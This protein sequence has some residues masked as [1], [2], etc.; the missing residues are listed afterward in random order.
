MAGKRANGE[1]SVYRRSDGRWVGQVTLS[2]GT[3]KFYYAKTRQDVS[4][5]VTEALRA[6]DQGLPIGYGARLTVAAYLDDWLERVKPTIRPRTWQRYKELLAHVTPTLGK[7]SVTRLQPQQLERLYAALLAEGLSSTTVH[8]LSTVLH[9]ALGDGMRKGVLAR[10][11]CELADAPKMR[12]HHIQAL[13]PEQAIALLKAAQGDRNEVLYTLALLTGMRQGEILAL[14]W[15]DLDLDSATPSLQVRGSLQRTRESGLII[16]EPKTDHSR[17]RVELAPMAV[18]ALKRHKARQAAER[19]ALGPA[20]D[21]SGLVFTNTIG[22]P[23]EAR[24]LLRSYYALLKS[25]DLPRIRFHDLRHSTASLLLALGVHPKIVSS[26]LGHSAI[27]ITMDTYSHATPGLQRDAVLAL[28]RL[29]A[30]Q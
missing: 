27:G 30:A 16:G 23:I 25:A 21:D 13:T 29:L 3:R 22:R 24:N 1:G 17:R 5:K 15:D 10:N 8:H 7:V 2:D 19:L 6:L 4:R 12:R 26:L 28:E 11:V 9:H 14:H 20:W 18:E